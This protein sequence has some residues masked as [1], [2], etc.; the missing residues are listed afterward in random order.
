VTASPNTPDDFGA[1]LEKAQA[2]LEDLDGQRR[3]EVEA[4]A[5]GYR[6][7]HRTGWEIGYAHAHH[8][9]AAEWTAIAARVRAMADAATF[10]ERAAMDES[11][12]RGEMCAA[13]CGRCSRCARADAVARRGGD[14]LGEQAHRGAA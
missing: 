9:M 13:A 2:L 8:E 5:T 3:R 14:Y 12:A 7:G 10:N 6:D 1:M 11:A 4:Y